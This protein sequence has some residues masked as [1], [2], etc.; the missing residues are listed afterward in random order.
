MK[1]K[2]TLSIDK[3]IVERAKSYIKKQGRSLSSLVE[4]YL[5]V[6]TS[7]QKVRKN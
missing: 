3:K 2:L 7:G 6:I 5:R 1:T 4:T